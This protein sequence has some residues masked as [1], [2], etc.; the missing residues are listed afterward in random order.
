MF[1]P[2]PRV[3]AAA[4]ELSAKAQAPQCS[5]TLLLHSFKSLKHDPFL[6]LV[7]LDPRRE[8]S[9]DCSDRLLRPRRVSPLTLW[10]RW[11]GTL[12]AVNCA[13]SWADGGFLLTAVFFR[14]GARR[15]WR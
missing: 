10:G 5:A 4:I 11:D 12:S 2:L 15:I 9:H 6:E 14:H 8:L 1:K 13:T 3:H 7:A